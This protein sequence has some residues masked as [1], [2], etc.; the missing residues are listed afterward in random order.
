M[1]DSRFLSVPYLV[2]WV[3]GAD[4]ENLRLGYEVLLARFR[5]RAATNTLEESI[6]RVGMEV[7][8]NTELLHR[9]KPTRL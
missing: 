9:V 5:M 6:L 4:F 2:R 8:F 3:R 7:I 1:G